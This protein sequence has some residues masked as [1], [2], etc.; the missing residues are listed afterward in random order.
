MSKDMDKWADLRAKMHDLLARGSLVATKAECDAYNAE[1][2]ALFAQTIE[3]FD[4]SYKATLKK[5]E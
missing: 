3:E 2:D 5:G 4:K 1:C